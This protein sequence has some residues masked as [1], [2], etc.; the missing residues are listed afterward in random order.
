MTSTMVWL[1]ALL[2]ALLI[3]GVVL[4]QFR[5]RGIQLNATQKTLEDAEQKFRE[6]SAY[7]ARVAKIAAELQQA[8]SFESLAKTFFS[9]TV[10]M[11]G[12]H[13]GTLYVWDED[14]HRLAQVGA[15]GAQKSDAQPR[16][17]GL[18]D[19]LVGQCAQDRQGV[20]ILNLPDTTLRIVSG[21]G[22]V[23][24][25]Q[26]MV[27]ALVQKE[28][29]VGVLEFAALNAFADKAQYLLEELMPTLAMSIEILDRSLRTLVLLDAKREQA[30]Q[31]E[32]QQA[33]LQDSFAKRDA[34]NQA[35]QAQVSELADARRAMLNIMEDL[36][37]TRAT[38]SIAIHTGSTGAT[39]INE[40]KTP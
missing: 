16:S 4:F 40:V 25:R 17:F 37:M 3:A 14:T 11:I 33:A 1:I 5:A 34:A 2:L 18:G 22:S 8:D 12:A 23:V 27:Q 15:Y 21:L 38:E 31:L 7:R 10:E 29:V 28:K 26:V 30:A 24:P 36:E 13:Y 6:F 35:L 39:T 19:G 32:I 20:K 9:R